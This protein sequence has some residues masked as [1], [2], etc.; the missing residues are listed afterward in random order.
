MSENEKPL[1][2]PPSTP[3]GGKNRFS[4]EKPDGPLMADRLAMAMASGQI[5][6]FMKKELPDNEQSRSLAMMMLGMSGMMPQGCMP[7]PPMPDSEGP[8]APVETGEMHAQ[9]P[10]DMVKA[11]NSGDVKELMAM[12]EKEYLKRS[13]NAAPGSPEKG[14]APPVQQLSGS[15]KEVIDKLMNIASENNTTVDW[16]IMRALK[17]YLREYE[18]SGRL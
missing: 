17:Q 15:E 12:L 11:V 9:V 5:E 3:F 2:Q 14:P 8:A 6:E 16:L 7:Q 1:P 4:E 10:E 18:N 13:G